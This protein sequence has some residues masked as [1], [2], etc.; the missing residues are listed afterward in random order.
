[1]VPGKLHTTVVQ[2]DLVFIKDFQISLVV[3]V[4]KIQP[5]M[6]TGSHTILFYVCENK[7]PDLLHESEISN[8]KPSALSLQALVSDL[9]HRFSP[10]MAQI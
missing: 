4:D 6:C 5:K 10:D 8:L 7:G 3:N 9:E 2:V 1:M